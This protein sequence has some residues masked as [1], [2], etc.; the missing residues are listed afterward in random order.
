[1]SPRFFVRWSLLRILRAAGAGF[2]ISLILAGLSTA[3]YEIGRQSMALLE[4]FLAHAIPSMTVFAPG[5][6]IGGIALMFYESLLGRFLRRRVCLPIVELLWHSVAVTLGAV[7]G[8]VASSVFA[9]DVRPHAQQLGGAAILFLALAL[10]LDAVMLALRGRFDV[11]LGDGKTAEFVWTVIG[12]GIAVGAS[13]QFYRDLQAAEA[14]SKEAPA[15][16]AK[17]VSAPSRGGVARCRSV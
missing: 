2:F 6:F 4:K 8:L 11:H 12:I 3:P 15:C 9:P 16:L 5:F 7:A 10:Q 1:M 17:P 14:S 13:I